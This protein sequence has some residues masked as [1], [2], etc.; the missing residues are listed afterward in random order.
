MP[1]IEP[2]I[3]ILKF[4][5]VARIFVDGEIDFRE[6]TDIAFN[7]TTHYGFGRALNCVR[8][9]LGPGK[10][11]YVAANMAEP[12]KTSWERWQDENPKAKK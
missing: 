7:V 1:P 6:I 5:D 11:A 2:I 4:D 10:W 9:G 3:P 8:V 12:L